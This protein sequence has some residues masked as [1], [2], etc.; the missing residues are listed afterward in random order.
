MIN[1]GSVANDCLVAKRVLCVW[2]ADCVTDHPP[3]MPDSAM[4]H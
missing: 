1:G 3:R 4:I 2:A